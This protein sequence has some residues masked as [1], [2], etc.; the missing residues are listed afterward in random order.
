MLH[1]VLWAIL[2]VWMGLAFVVLF[3]IIGMLFWGGA[4]LVRDQAGVKDELYCPAQHRNLKVRGVPRRFVIEPIYSDV[5]RC[6]AWGR[7]AVRCNKSC[8]HP[9][10]TAA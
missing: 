10:Q 3:S 9:E 7:G 6:E 2:A 5:R 1:Y 4:H 8:I